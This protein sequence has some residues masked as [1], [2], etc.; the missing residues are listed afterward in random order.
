MSRGAKPIAARTAGDPALLDARVVARGAPALLAARRCS[1]DGSGARGIGGPALLRSASC[2]SWAAGLASGL[3]ASY[4][5][6]MSTKQ[7]DNQLVVFRD[8]DAD[9]A[10]LA[11]STASSDQT[12]E[13]DDGKI[14]PLVEVELPSEYL[15]S[16]KARTVDTEGSVAPHATAGPRR[17]ACGPAT[18]S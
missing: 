9:C 13:W 14:Y 12:I 7:G 18:E 11:L 17:P 16:G 10:F 3:A 1:S 8:L 2:C 6:R 4:K 15:P 5:H